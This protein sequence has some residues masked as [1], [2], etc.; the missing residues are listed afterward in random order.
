MRI[1]SLA[2]VFG[3]L[4]Y[5]TM[6]RELR[7]VVFDKNELSSELLT[8]YLKEFDGIKNV[9]AFTDFVA[10]FESCKNDAPAFAIVDIT[11]T[12]EFALD[13]IA[14]LSRASIPTI[15]TSTSNS[16][17]TIIKA[18]RAGATE[19]LTKPVIKSDLH[20]A[21]IKIQEP[22][23]ETLQAESKVITLFSSKGG[24]GKTT[25]ASNVALELAK[26]TGKKTALIDLNFSL[27]EVS[28]FLNLKPSFNLSNVLENIDKISSDDISKMFEKY[29][30]TELYLLTESENGENFSTITHN[31]VTRFLKALKETFAYIVVDT[32]TVA[33]DK[34][35]K[36][37]LASDY[38]LFVTSVNMNA[39]KNTKK[40][41]D[42]IKS[43]GVNED[44]IK[45]LLNRYVESEEL[46]T[47]EIE[48]EIGCKIYKRIPNNY[49]TVMSAINKSISVSEENINSNVAESFRELAVMLSDSIMNNSLRVLRGEHEY[50]R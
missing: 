19:F 48:S 35:F 16:S 12:Q 17:S 3:M 24:V 22:V 23:Q 6:Q 42:L 33:D 31:R 44:K 28:E 40:S 14:K 32:P 30:G 20:K 39:M 37:L 7:V 8:I 25:I 41:L 4:Y 29:N 13:V 10:G 18:L 36:T 1:K 38:V 43:K 50:K 26:Q 47:E 27:G 9:E 49:F 2:D 45:I 46:S 21:I 11:E 15:V 5:T 34:V